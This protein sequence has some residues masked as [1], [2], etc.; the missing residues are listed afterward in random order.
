[1]ATTNN[2]AAVTKNDPRTLLCQVEFFIVL[3]PPCFLLI[4]FGWKCS[5]DTRGASIPSGF[6][7][8]LHG[9]AILLLQERLFRRTDDA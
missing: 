4:A 9:G 3:P 2:N 5:L 1:L 8:P 6:W 7:E